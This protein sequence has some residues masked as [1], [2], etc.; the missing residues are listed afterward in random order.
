MIYAERL[1]DTIITC[2]QLTIDHLNKLSPM[3]KKSSSSKNKRGSK[4]NKATRSLS[5]QQLFVQLMEYNHLGIGI[6]SYSNWDGTTEI[7]EFILGYCGQLIRGYQVV[8][9]EYDC[10]YPSA[11]FY[12]HHQA[13]DYLKRSQ[14]RYKIKASFISSFE[15]R[16]QVIELKKPPYSF[17]KGEPKELVAQ[18]FREAQVAV[19]GYNLVLS[20]RG[21]LDFGQSV[22]IELDPSLEEIHFDQVKDPRYWDRE[23]EQFRETEL[24]KKEIPNMSMSNEDKAMQHGFDPVYGF[25]K[26]PGQRK[27]R[28]K[29][30][31]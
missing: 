27:R 20:N 16:N 14:K 28:K 29:K 8:S 10:T 22:Q 2:I 30:R 18:F 11:Y 23:I 3:A 15:K 19:F 17:F 12:C 6:A 1:R 4:L 9:Y 24:A 13:A 31:K 25:R 21:V 5:T 7:R 26:R